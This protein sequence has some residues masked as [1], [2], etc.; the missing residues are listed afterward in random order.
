MLTSQTQLPPMQ[1]PWPL[2]FPGQ[3]EVLSVILIA[4]SSVFIFECNSGW[5]Q[6]SPR[7]S[8]PCSRAFLVVFSSTKSFHSKVVLLSIARW[9][10]YGTDTRAKTHGALFAAF[11]LVDDNKSPPSP[12]TA[13]AWHGPPTRRFQ[14][15]RI[16]EDEI[17]SYRLL[18]QLK[19]K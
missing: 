2:Q 11:W 5:V 6:G 8:R 13:P 17:S 16:S 9:F 15:A 1:D 12:P 4:F 19:P 14:F 3:L 18:S 7:T 10:I